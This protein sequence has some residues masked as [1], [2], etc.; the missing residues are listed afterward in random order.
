MPLIW[1]SIGPSVPVELMISLSALKQM[2]V[3][4]L[5]AFPGMIET[6]GFK[7]LP[8]ESHDSFRRFSRS[9]IA[10][11]Q[12]VDIVSCDRMHQICKSNQIAIV[13]SR[14]K[15]RRNIRGFRDVANQRSS[16]N[17]F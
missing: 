11:D 10:F 15:I 4:A 12:N 17:R 14:W 8:K 5:Y 7:A 3:A 13:N 1:G 2:S 9:A 16:C 6:Q